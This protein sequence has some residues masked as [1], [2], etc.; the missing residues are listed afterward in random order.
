VSARRKILIIGGTGG[1]GG[2]GITDAPSDGQKYARRNAAWAVVNDAYIDG[3]VQYYA[4]LPVTL[5]TPALGAAYLVREASGTWLIS[6]KPAGIYVRLANGGTLADW[7]YAGTFPDVFSDANFSLYDDADA[8]KELGFS[9]GGVTAGQKRILTPLD[10][11]YT[12]EET[13]HASKHGSVGSDPV[14]ITPTQAGLSNVT[15]D[16]QTKAAIVPNTA[17]ASGEIPV[18]N[19]GGTAYAKAAVSGDATLASTG[20]LTIAAGAVTLAKMANLAQ[21]QFIGR[22]T[23]STGVPETATITA[24]ARTVLDDATVAAMVDTLGGTAAQ[25]TGAIVRATSPTLTT[26]NIGTPSAGTLTSCTGLPTAGLVDDA[27]TNAKLANM[28]ASTFKARK[29]ASTGDPED[30]TVLEAQ[31]LLNPLTINTQTDSY[32]LVLTDAGKLVQMNKGTANTLTVPKN[33]SVAFPT[34][35]TILCGQI[36]AGLTTVSP[37]D[38]DVTINSRGAALKSGGQYAQWSLV[39][40]DTDVWV[41]SG[42]ITT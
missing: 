18:G 40:R 22:T 28:A 41:M 24:A 6:R 12:V 36:G 32:T 39:K 10:K 37:V 26:P 14:T 20:A 17:P 15:N 31:T 11:N 30:C 35:T 2:G 5:G 13:G 33:S 38:G 3:E 4:D 1:G 9:L 25:G 21:D 8:T 16:A 19:A 29:T 23:A 7:T 27:V 34:G 42:D